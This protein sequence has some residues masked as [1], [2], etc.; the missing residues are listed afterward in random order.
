MFG[1]WTKNTAV[2]GLLVMAMFAMVPNASAVQDL[3]ANDY[4]TWYLANTVW[5]PYNNGWLPNAELLKW[6]GD[7]PRLDV[8]NKKL[9]WV[10]NFPATTVADNMGWLWGECVSFGKAVSHVQTAGYTR[11]RQV[12]AG[13]IVQGTIIGVFKSDGTYD[14]WGGTGHIA[15]FDRY[16]IVQGQPIG[17]RVWDQNFVSSN[18]VGRHIL[19][20]SGF[21]TYNA[22]NYYVVQIP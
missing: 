12:M 20:P 1:K 22:N 4:N 21:G 8:N 15:V 17:F 7:G 6:E 18:V 2:I 9:R 5:T 16:L 3:K 14:S 13:G 19:Y 10:G 11:G